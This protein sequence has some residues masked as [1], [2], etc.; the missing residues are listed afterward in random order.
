MP[1]PRS[2]NKEYWEGVC[3][4]RS[5]LVRNGEPHA[6]VWVGKGD[7][8]MVEVEIVGASDGDPSLQ[9]PSTLAKNSSSSSSSPAPPFAPDALRPRSV[10]NEGAKRSLHS[11]LWPRASKNPSRRVTW[12]RLPREQEGDVI[13]KWWFDR[14]STL[15]ERCIEIRGGPM[16]D[17]L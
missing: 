9:V 14:L 12:G 16:F 4:K 17:Q 5:D 10:T 6:I 15:E 7:E 11:S 1:H 3:G 8:V 2:V 13:L